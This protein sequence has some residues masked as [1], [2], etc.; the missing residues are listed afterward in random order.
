MTDIRLNAKNIGVLAADGWTLW[1]RKCKS[2]FRGYGLW[3]YIEGPDSKPPANVAKMDE[4]TQMNDRIVGALCQVVDNAI[5][6]EIKNLTMAIEAW[7]KL[8]GKTY[9]SGVISK[10]NALQT[11]MRTC[12]TTLDTVTATIANI[13]DLIK[14]I[15]DKTAPTKEEMLITLY[16]H[17]MADGEFD[18]LHKLMIG[19]MTSTSLTITPDEIT[20]HLEMEAQEARYRDSIKEGEKILMAQ[21]KKQ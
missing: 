2:V 14:I 5:S 1:S 15:Y 20:H 11:A 6:Q 4:W 13:K 12:F 9:Q 16:F 10:F 18:W 3:M 8:K 21:Q 17:A 19:N 7:N